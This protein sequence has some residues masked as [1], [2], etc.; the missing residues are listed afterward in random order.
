MG[1]WAGRC[2]GSVGGARAQ[3]LGERPL[4]AVMPLACQPAGMCTPACRQAAK[5]HTRWSHTPP[6]RTFDG[7]EVHDEGGL[8]PGRQVAGHRPASR[9]RGASPWRGPRGHR[10][11]CRLDLVLHRHACSGCISRPL[12]HSFTRFFCIRQF[13]LSIIQPSLYRAFISSAQQHS[14]PPAGARCSKPNNFSQRATRR[15]GAANAEAAAVAPAASATSGPTPPC[16]VT[17]L[18]GTPPAGS[19]AAP[20][21]PAQRCSPWQTG[22]RPGVVVGGIRHRRGGSRWVGISQR[23]A[24]ARSEAAAAPPPP[25]NRWT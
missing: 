17:H 1:C 3:S 15:R 13:M 5:R 22:P 6:R 11:A 10:H 25:P 9:G 19:S 16:H 21:A 20:R 24:R 2:R 18:G 4:H 12:A 23:A 14:A 8:L 7:V